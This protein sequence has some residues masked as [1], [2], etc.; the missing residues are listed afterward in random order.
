MIRFI[1]KR[2]T[3]DKTKGVFP[4]KWDELDAA[5]AGPIFLE[6][7]A[8]LPA[9]FQRKLPSEAEI[10]AVNSGGAELIF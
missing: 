7:E 9:R 8:D 4:N 10:E 3:N 2:Q 1:G 5:P 6:S